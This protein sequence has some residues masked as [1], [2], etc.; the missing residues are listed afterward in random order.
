MLQRFK[1]Q[2]LIDE[3]RK[4]G[5]SYNVYGNRPDRGYMVALNGNESV[6]PLELIDTPEFAARLDK[7]ISQTSEGIFFGAWLEGENIYLDLALNIQDEQDA[8]LI[9]RSNNQLA[10]WDVKNERAIDLRL[11]VELDNN[12]RVVRQWEE[13]S[14]IPSI[15]AEQE[16]IEQAANRIQGLLAFLIED[17]G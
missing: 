16:R 17:E 11:K 5:F 15:R 12:G 13:K 10:I 8:I 6:I 2:L 4:G 3:I 9:G 7:Y 14:N 1:K